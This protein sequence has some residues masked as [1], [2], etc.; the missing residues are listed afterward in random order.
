MYTDRTEG[1]SYAIIKF[2]L[3][4]QVNYLACVMKIITS[5]L[6]YTN[7]IICTSKTLSQ[8][9]SA[10]LSALGHYLTYGY[11]DNDFNSIMMPSL[12]MERLLNP[13]PLSVLCV[14]INSV[15]HLQPLR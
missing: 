4:E 7:C 1:V 8:Y 10:L 12:N 9:T 15:Y 11:H 2:D 5:S 14:T 3:I 6:T 13:P